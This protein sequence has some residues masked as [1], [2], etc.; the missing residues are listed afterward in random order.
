MATSGGKEGRLV[1]C[2]S[3][4]AKMSRLTWSNAEPAENE[5]EDAQ[6]GPTVSLLRAL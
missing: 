5:S 4:T 1:F 6:N 2:V 3:D